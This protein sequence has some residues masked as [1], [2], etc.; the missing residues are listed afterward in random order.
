MFQDFLVLA[1]QTCHPTKHKI[2][3]QANTL[4]CELY[5]RNVFSFSRGIR[6]ILKRILL[7]HVKWS[8]LT[9]KGTSQII[10]ASMMIGTTN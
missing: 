4:Y 3:E 6:V 10:L 7:I 9:P 8:S 1:M 5:C 2:C